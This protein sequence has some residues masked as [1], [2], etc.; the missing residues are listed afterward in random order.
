MVLPPPNAIP[1]YPQTAPPP[2]V[3]PVITPSI[4]SPKNRPQ[5][6]FLSHFPHG[7]LMAALIIA[8][9]TFYLGFAST[10][11]YFRYFADSK[12]LATVQPQ[13]QLLGTTIEETTAPPS[14]TS[15]PTPNIQ[16]QPISKEKTFP[17]T[18]AYLLKSEV[19][20]IKADRSSP[21]QITTDGLPKANL[22]IS[23]NGLDLAYTTQLQPASS[24]DST[25]TMVNRQ[26]KK[27][28]TLLD[29]P[30]DSFSMI[31]FSPSGR[32]LSAWVNHG[33][34]VIV[35]DISTQKTT[36]KFSSANEKQGI[37]PITW[38]PGTDRVSFILDGE[39]FTANSQGEDIKTLALN[40]V[41]IKLGVQNNDVSLPPVW[42]SSGSLVALV[43]SQGIYLLSVDT[44]EETPIQITEEDYDL[45]KIPYRPIAF[46]ATNSHL[47]FESTPDDKNQN[48]FA[49]SIPEKKT[50]AIGGYGDSGLLNVNHNDLL[51]LLYR[52]SNQS[53][54]ARYSLSSWE[55]SRCPA[56]PYIYPIPPSASLLSPNNT[57]LIGLTQQN[58]VLTLSLTDTITCDTYDLVKTTDT[59]TNPLWL[60]N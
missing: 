1:P 6:Q 32:Y 18:L 33:L 39:L 40:V 55:E 44:L 47:I 45:D 8:T 22:I 2:P 19:H 11:G 60:P 48:L 36:L 41:G 54:L 59:L 25:I 10:T 49:Y 52:G 7:I 9:S 34:E 58:G 23:P 28:T 37:S 15:L 30:K 46:T 38:L 27:T 12:G 3:T 13:G 57:V 4:I 21:D 17:G 29:S 14:P 51:G 53:Q 43:R 20:T 42:S 26:S 5:N 35:V 50:V 24:P 16:I 56:T 31:R